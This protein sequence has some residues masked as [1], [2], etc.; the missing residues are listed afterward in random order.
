[1]TDLRYRID[2]GKCVSEA[3]GRT[4]FPANTLV[5]VA[6]LAFPEM[7]LMVEVTAVISQ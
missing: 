6:G 4:P 5:G 2:M 7:L 1:M 3:W